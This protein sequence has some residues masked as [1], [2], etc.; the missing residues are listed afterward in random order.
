M[1]DDGVPGVDDSGITRLSIVGGGGLM[2]CG[3]P[4]SC[5]PGK[6]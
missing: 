1:S 4:L 2:L 5:V 6:C 3:P